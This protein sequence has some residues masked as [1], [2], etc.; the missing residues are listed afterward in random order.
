M[1][2]RSTASLKNAFPV[3]NNRASK[4]IPVNA[5]T[6]RVNISTSASCLQGGCAIFS[7]TVFG[8]QEGFGRE[9]NDG[10]VSTAMVSSSHRIGRALAGLQKLAFG[11]CFNPADSARVLIVKGRHKMNIRCLIAWL[12]L[13][14]FATAG[15]VGPKVQTDFDPAAEFSGF[16]TYAFTGMTDRDQGGVLDNSLLRKRIEEMVGQQLTAKGL[17]QVGLEDH[18]D[19]LVHFWVGVKDKQQV[20]STGVMGGGYGG[21]YGW[22]TGYYG[23][24]VTTFQYQ[25]GTLVV[26][27]AESSKKELVWRATIVGTLA[28]SSEKN[29]EIAK[30]GVA[31]AFEDYP[32][33][34]K[35]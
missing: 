6:L 15:C 9:K 20:E 33:A 14:L 4:T 16:H 2:S 13:G 19:L 7:A 32:P 31:K 11:I 27:L 30:A 8:N 28:D 17:R 5:S 12:A 10:N 35:K 18:P 26:D 1:A 3:L 23:G 22:R 24:N 21:G 29:V 25:E 34:K